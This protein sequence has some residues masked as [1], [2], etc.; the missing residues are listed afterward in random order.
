MP[1]HWRDRRGA[2]KDLRD[3][4]PAGEVVTY[5]VDDLSPE[6]RA[7][8]AALPAAAEREKR[9][10]WASQIH[11]AQMGDLSAKRRNEHDHPRAEREKGGETMA[12]GVRLVAEQDEDSLAA[13]CATMRR[14]DV[15]EKWRITEAQLRPWCKNHGVSLPPRRSANAETHRR[16]VEGQSRR[17]GKPV[18]QRG[19]VVVGVLDPGPPPRDLAE[20]EQYRA[21]GLNPDDLAAP[22]DSFALRCLRAGL[23]RDLTATRRE[24]AAA[25]EAMHRMPSLRD[26]EQRI[27]QDL[28][29]VTRSLELL[30]A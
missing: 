16:R 1:L 20:A 4:A 29:A 25:E 9:H 5:R 14:E 12:K 6:D 18:E 21:E 17:Y 15:C 13:D 19:L 8:L 24:I 30:Q 3:D 22:D 10:G 27:G 7:R 2:P 28:A 26:A 23:E 11:A